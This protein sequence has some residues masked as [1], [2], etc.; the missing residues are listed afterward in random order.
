VDGA[1]AACFLGRIAHLVE[2]PYP[3]LE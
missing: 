1:P 3:F 2:N